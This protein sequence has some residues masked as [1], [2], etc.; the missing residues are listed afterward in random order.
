MGPDRERVLYEGRSAMSGRWI[1]VTT[2]WC[3]VDGAQ[4]PV[5]ELTLVGAARGRRPPRPGKALVVLVV[6]AALV[7][8]VIAIRSGQT[9]QIW[10]ALAVTAA[11]T[12]AIT[13]LPGALGRVLRRP[14]QIWALYRGAQVLL[15]DTD[16]QEQYGQVA[17]ALVRARELNP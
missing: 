17:R 8:S 16:D 9:R 13:V 1:C 5:A 2:H 14:F 15:F 10:Y 6:L 4:Y 11:A 3:R 12:T 7:L